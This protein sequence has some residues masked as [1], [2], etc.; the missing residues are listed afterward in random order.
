MI[1]GAKAGSRSVAAPADT[2]EVAPAVR[3]GSRLQVRLPRAQRGL[4][5]AAQVRRPVRHAIRRSHRHAHRA[6]AVH[7]GPPNAF[8]LPGTQYR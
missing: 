5:T 4:K 3:L 8:G 7:S 1:P 6:Y 2:E